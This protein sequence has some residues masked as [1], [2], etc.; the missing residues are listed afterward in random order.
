MAYPALALTYLSQAA[1]LVD[2]PQ[3]YA[4]LFWS[5]VPGRVQWPMLILATA[6]T[7]IASQALIS[8]SFSLVSQVSGLPTRSL[9]SICQP[10]SGQA[11]SSSVSQSARRSSGPQ[12]PTPVTSRACCSQSVGQLLVHLRSVNKI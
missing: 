11:C 9:Q 3:N 6:A 12:S 5:W 10:T 8:A 2:E 4:S 1:Y 7:I